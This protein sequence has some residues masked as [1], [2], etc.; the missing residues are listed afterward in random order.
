MQDLYKMPKTMEELKREI[1]KKYNAQRKVWMK[2]SD[3][4]NPKI[5]KVL[6]KTLIRE[7]NKLDKLA[8]RY[9]DLL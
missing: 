6:L 8:K 5:K 3:D 1:E 2:V 7:K 4:Y 9:N